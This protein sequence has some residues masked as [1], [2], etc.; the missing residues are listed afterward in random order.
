M[1]ILPNTVEKERI[2][3]AKFAGKNIEIQERKGEKGEETS[4]EKD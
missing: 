2:Y 3:E 1:T 4:L